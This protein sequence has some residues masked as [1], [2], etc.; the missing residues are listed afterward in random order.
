MAGTTFPLL[1]CKV[2][3][4]SPMKRGLKAPPFRLNVLVVVVK[5]TSPM[6]R[7]LKAS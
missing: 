6:K 4:T 5:E 7:G 3:E 1:I 2:K